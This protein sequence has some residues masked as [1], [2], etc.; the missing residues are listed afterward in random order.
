[1]NKLAVAKLGKSVGLKGFVRFFDL[2]DFP[3]QFKK[4]AKFLGENG[5]IYTLKAV[6]KQSSS[7]L[8]EGFE[9]IELAK[10]LTNK[11]LFKSEEATRKECN[12]K[13]GE[14]FYFDILG[15]KVFESSVKH[16]IKND[17]NLSLEQNDSSN[18]KSPLLLGKI[19]DILETSASYLLLVKTDESLVKKGFA[20][21][22]YLPYADFYIQKIN[23]QNKE[24]YSQNALTLLESLK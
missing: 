11:T 1:M 15:C 23:T 12:L 5:E 8:I 10:T 9:S 2:S 19:K 24:I 13:K 17:K 6:D 16:L 18:E 22:F 14:Y 21:E 3:S 4:G 7:L 20:K